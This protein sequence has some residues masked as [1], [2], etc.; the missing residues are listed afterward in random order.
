MSYNPY[1]MEEFVL[2][3]SVPSKFRFTHSSL[4]ESSVYQK[5]TPWAPTK[6]NNA[7]AG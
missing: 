3:M 1:V 6:P 5:V 7:E 2:I 4:R